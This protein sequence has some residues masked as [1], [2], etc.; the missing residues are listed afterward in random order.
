MMEPPVAPV[1]RA[2]IEP[3]AVDS[4]LKAYGA[5]A[6]TEP[7]GLLLGARQGAVVWI[8]EA[9]AL[10]NVHPSPDRAFL[11]DPD[12]QIRVATAARQRGREVI[13]AW[14][15]HVRGGPFP[16]EQDVSGAAPVED[17]PSRHAVLVI[18][19]RGTRGRAVMRAYA[20][21]RGGPDEIPLAL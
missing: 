3:E 5:A 17:L 4:L 20:L 11:L 15:G 2:W 16:G 18:V 13:G 9:P 12:E 8:R 10:R 7:C 19:G 14:H 1:A 21:G 6:A